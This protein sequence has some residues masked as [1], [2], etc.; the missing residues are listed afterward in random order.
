MPW[1]TFTVSSFEPRSDGDR[2]GAFIRMT[3]KP[4]VE[5]GGVKIG[6]LQ[7]CRP[8]MR[9]KNNMSVWVPFLSH[10]GTGLTAPVNG[11]F[12]DNEGRD[13]PLYKMHQDEAVSKD[14]RKLISNAKPN[15]VGD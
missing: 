4:S 12:I 1:G 10:G 3:F 5:T 6:L 8:R 15:Y 7:I 14:Q 2:R 11:F 13:S 9:R